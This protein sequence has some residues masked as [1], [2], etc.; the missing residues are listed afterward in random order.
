MKDH[1]RCISV[2]KGQQSRQIA[3]DT[4]LR[5]I[6]VGRYVITISQKKVT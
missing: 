1:E 5:K 3:Y 2:N 4:L 6:V